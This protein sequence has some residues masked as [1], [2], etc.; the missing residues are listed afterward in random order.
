MELYLTEIIRGGSQIFV[1]CLLGVW[2]RRAENWFPARRTVHTHL[3]LKITL[4][5]T[6]QA[7]DKHL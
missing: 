2:Q 5:N 3:E 7:H 6:E 1:V 4:P